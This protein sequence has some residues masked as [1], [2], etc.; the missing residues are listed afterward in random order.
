MSC[1]L[2][3]GRRCLWKPAKNTNGSS[4]GSSNDSSRGVIHCP[5]RVNGVDIA[6]TDIR[7]PSALTGAERGAVDMQYGWLARR[8]RIVDPRA[9]YHPTGALIDTVSFTTL[10][11]FDGCQRPWVIAHYLQDGTQVRAQTNVGMKATT[12]MDINIDGPAAFNYIAFD[13]GAGRCRW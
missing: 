4:N 2:I 7:L 6:L 3:A 12:A 8:E 1:R 10:T 11:V 5:M 9:P 13:G